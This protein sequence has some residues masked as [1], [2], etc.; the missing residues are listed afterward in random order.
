MQFLLDNRPVY[1]P[2]VMIK[3]CEDNGFDVSEWYGKANSFVDRR[4]ADPSYGY[5]LV[6]SDH[7]LIADSVKDSQ[8]GPGTFVTPKGTNKFDLTIIYD[9]L[10]EA[11]ETVTRTITD[12]YVD[13]YI[14]ITPSFDPQSCFYLVK[15]VDARFV[16]DT[17]EASYKGIFRDSIGQ[18][19]N[20]VEA[21]LTPDQLQAEYDLVE[22]PEFGEFIYLESSTPAWLNATSSTT[23]VIGTNTDGEEVTIA[24]PFTWKQIFEEIFETFS[25]TKTQDGPYFPYHDWPKLELN[26]D[27]VEFPEITPQNVS[28]DGISGTTLLRRL[29]FWTNTTILYKDGVFHFVHIENP[30]SSE[31]DSEGNTLTEL[32]LLAETLGKASDYKFKSLSTACQHV[33]ESININLQLVDIE[34]TNNQ[35]EEYKTFNIPVLE[36]RNNSKHTGIR[37]P[38]F[39]VPHAYTSERE[40]D[41]E[42]GTAGPTDRINAITDHYRSI[43]TSVDESFFTHY[44]ETD[45]EYTGFHL[46]YPSSWVE[47]VSVYDVA[48]GP[49]TR[50]ESIL[51]INDWSWLFPPRIIPRETKFSII[52]AKVDSSTEDTLQFKEAKVLV[53]DGPDGT[54]GWA[55]NTLRQTYSEN[56]YVILVR[57]YVAE[58]RRET[59][60]TFL[61]DEEQIIVWYTIDKIPFV[62]VKVDKDDLTYDST[63]GKFT[64]TLSK[65]IL[66]NGRVPRDDDGDDTNDPTIIITNN[67]PLNKDH[68]PAHVYIAYDITAGDNDLSR[69][70]TDDTHNIVSILAAREGFD[71][72]SPTNKKVLTSHETSGGDIVIWDTLTGSGGGIT[73]GDVINIIENYLEDNPQNGTPIETKLAFV[74]EEGGVASTDTTFKFNSATTLTGN[75]P[76]TAGFC[77]NTF[78][79]AFAYQEPIFLILKKNGIWTAK[80]AQINIIEAQVFSTEAILETTQT[81]DFTDARAIVGVIPF[82]GNGVANNVRTKLFFASNERLLL[83]QDNTGDWTPIKLRN[84]GVIKVLDKEVT[85]SMGTFTIA[86]EDMIGVQGTKP[87]FDI[88]VTNYPPLNTANLDEKIVFCRYDR[89]AGA[90]KEFQWTTADGANFYA[91]LRGMTDYDN[92]NTQVIEHIPNAEEP[93]WENAG[94]CDTP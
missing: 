4:G 79:T 69:W 41:Q 62:R 87:D 19:F 73:E 76:T 61:D 64:T 93:R 30:D 58:W 74:N 14:N 6:G 13:H 45:N 9:E 44:P 17:V 5:F 15:L 50:I 94:E 28:S 77:D 57:G 22:K 39:L 53:G 3:T 60:L 92:N 52:L 59:A 47:R 81:F 2:H 16:F 40:Y 36:G 20:K 31:S 71:T 72:A 65:L 37:V 91:M 38:E 48:E 85:R 18:W 1:S 66:V 82:E 78:K 10:D 88:M 12:L 35:L 54:T 46:V 42:A 90:T 29:L 24:K 63:S 11:G 7:I 89:S 55:V 86:K 51:P 80:K 83:F 32:Q 75:S 33:P 49:Y 43:W 34:R 21:F 56:D 68:L 27:E 8:V 67:P 25:D 23:K 26:F 84:Y 70:T